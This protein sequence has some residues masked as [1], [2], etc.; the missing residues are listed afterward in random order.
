MK[1][2]VYFISIAF[3]RGFEVILGLKIWII[4]FWVWSSDHYEGGLNL[5]T[6]QTPILVRDGS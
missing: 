2:R 5:F 4:I 6:H 3:C 1:E